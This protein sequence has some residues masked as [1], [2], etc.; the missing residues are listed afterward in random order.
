MRSRVSTGMARD[1]N[2]GTSLRSEGQRVVGESPRLKFESYS[3]ETTF[4]LTLTVISC[5][6]IHACSVYSKQTLWALSTC[7]I[8]LQDFQL[9]FFAAI[10]ADTSS[11]DV[12]SN[13]TKKKAKRK[14]K[15]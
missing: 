7:R 2:L 4:L 10:R 11:Q 1:Q 15:G 8:A 5:D 9:L 12:S 3:N 13:G 6:L 14:D